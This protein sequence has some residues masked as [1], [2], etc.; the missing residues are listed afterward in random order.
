MKFAIAALIGL[1]SAIKIREDKPEKPAG[2]PEAPSATEALDV[3]EEELEEALAWMFDEIDQDGS[4]CVSKDEGED[5]VLAITEWLGIE[6]DDE[7]WEDLEAAFDEHDTS[8]DGALQG[9]EA[10]ALVDAMWESHHDE[11]I[12]AL[13]DVDFGEIEDLWCAEHD[14]KDDEELDLAQKE[15]PAPAHERFEMTEEELDAALEWVWGEMDTNE[16][17]DVCKEEAA[18]AVQW[19][20]DALEME[21]PQDVWDE[22]DAAYDEFA[23]E[24]GVMQGSEALELAEAAWEEHADDI[25]AGIKENWDALEE[26]WCAENGCDDDDE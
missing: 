18:A 11:I 4:G 1:A 12:D 15:G 25:V 24:D 6:L 9:E 7:D 5:A 21:I 17:G 10:R 16:D 8:E 19:V 14:C 26:A 20:A 3:T 2:K 23:G 22:L 13:A